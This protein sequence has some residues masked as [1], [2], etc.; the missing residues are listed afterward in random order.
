MAR[1][2]TARA[3]TA[4]DFN[5]LM[6]MLDYELDSVENTDLSIARITDAQMALTASDVAKNQ[7]RAD[8]SMASFGQAR[9]I[10]LDFIKGIV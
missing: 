4:S 5:R 1:A 6:S 7:A 2:R 9:S 10:N 8:A 3:T